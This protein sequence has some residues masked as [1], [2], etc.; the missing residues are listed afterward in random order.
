[1]ESELIEIIR[2][3]GDYLAESRDFWDGQ[4]QTLDPYIA[5]DPDARTRV[6]NA[7]KVQA[8][9][10]LLLLITESTG[11][12]DEALVRAKLDYRVDRNAEGDFHIN[13]LE[14]DLWLRMAD[15][16]LIRTLE[17]IHRRRSDPNF[18]PFEGYL[19]AA[20]AEREFN[21]AASTVKKA[22]QEG[23]I[24]A[25]KHGR[26]WWIKREDAARQWGKRGF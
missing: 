3:A 9:D 13:G 5:D 8:V 4:M 6:S 14:E 18:D 19:T 26:D 7:Q 21:L 1:M 24:R 15:M 11:E 22:A 12:R 16:V 17:V 25:R 10:K 23:R 20:E 2:A